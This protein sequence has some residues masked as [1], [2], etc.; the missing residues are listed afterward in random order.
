MQ[1]RK[2]GTYEFRKRLPEALAGKPAPAHIRESFSELVNPDNSCFKREFVRSLGTKEEREAKR[3]DHREALRVSLCGGLGRLGAKGGMDFVAGDLEGQD[4]VQLTKP[5]PCRHRGEPQPS[6]SCRA[7]GACP[8]PWHPRC[9]RP[10]IRSPRATRGALRR[11]LARDVGCS[12][13]VRMSKRGCRERRASRASCSS[14]PCSSLHWRSGR[15]HER[16][17]STEQWFRNSK[18]ESLKCPFLQGFAIGELQRD[19]GTLAKSSAR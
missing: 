11:L 1:R 2:S 16:V 14:V 9:P 10:R 5:P 19:F 15:H 6:S 13:S 18:T 7:L 12:W 17:C 4:G 3:R 8:C